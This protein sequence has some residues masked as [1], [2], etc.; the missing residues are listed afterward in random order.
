[1]LPKCVLHVQHD[2]FS[3]FNQSDHCFLAPS[4]PLTSSLLSS[5]LTKMLTKLASFKGDLPKLSYTTKTWNFSS[6][7]YRQSIDSGYTRLSFATKR[8]LETRTHKFITGNFNDPNFHRYW[9]FFGDA[10]SQNDK[11][12]KI[13]GE[14]KLQ[15]LAWVTK[16][17]ELRMPLSLR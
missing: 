10:C 5:L 16:L 6:G 17:T 3:S 1:M 15:S 9:K 7:T 12:G 13:L 11:P 8:T 2:Y 14:P 4:L